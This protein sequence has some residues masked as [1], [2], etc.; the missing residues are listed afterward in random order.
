M[1]LH[2]PVKTAVSAASVHSGA[3]LICGVAQVTLQPFVA[4][5]PPLMQ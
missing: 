5:P 2:L 1:P 3:P 4:P